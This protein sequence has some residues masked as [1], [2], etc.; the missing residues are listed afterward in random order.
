[1]KKL[2]KTFRLRFVIITIIIAVFI[3]AIMVANQKQA[4]V[5][6]MV[7]LVPMELFFLQNDMKS[8]NTIIEK[9]IIEDK[10][11]ISNFYQLITLLM[12]FPYIILIK[13]VF[14]NP[15]STLLA[16]FT[17]V[18]GFALLIV[19]L[20]DNKENPISH[21]GYKKKKYT[22]YFEVVH[23]IMVK[24]HKLPL[25]DLELIHMVRMFI[26]Q[27]SPLTL[28]VKEGITEEEVRKHVI[29][30]IENEVKEDIHEKE[31]IRKEEER[32]K[33]EIQ[34]YLDLIN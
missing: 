10:P 6:T 31:K 18:S 24:Y 9:K 22:L 33:E 19:M 2:F 26:E 16:L 28:F 4:L 34:S 12:I 25:D 13:Y 1:M 17:F 3:T 5:I 29:S 27:H 23:K 30:Y 32:K 20:I 14:N 8:I 15:Q 11:I 7:L 21:F